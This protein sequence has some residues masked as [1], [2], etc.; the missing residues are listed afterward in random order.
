[1]ACLNSTWGIFV[2][3]HKYSTQCEYNLCATMR[4]SHVWHKQIAEFFTN[5]VF[6]F[7]LLIVYGKQAYKSAI[8]ASLIDIQASESAI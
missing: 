1:M 7:P 4:H 8:L 2:W 3:N 6:P 5:I